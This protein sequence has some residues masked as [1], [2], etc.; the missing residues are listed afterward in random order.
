LDSGEPKGPSK[1]ARLDTLRGAPT[2][3]PEPAVGD[4]L[5]GRYRLQS[6]IGRGG[7]GRVFVAENLSIGIQVAIKVVHSGLLADNEFRQRFQREAQIIASIDHPNV[8]RFFDLVLGDPAFLVMEYVRGPTLSQIL[9]REGTMQIARAVDLAVRLCWGLHSVHA[10]GVVHRDLKPS[11]IIVAADVERGEM[12]KVI[13][14]GLA[15]IAGATT[16]GAQLTRTGQI[17]GTP[18]YMSP[19]QITGGTVDARAD[20]YSLACVLFEMLTNRTPFERSE[21]VQVLYR[22]IHE[23]PPSLSKWRPDAPPALVAVLSRGLAKAPSDRFGSMQEMAQALT[24]AVEKRASRTAPLR[25]RLLRGTA[26]VLAGAATGGL[27][28]AAVLLR[29]PT[30]DATAAG[31]TLVLSSTPSDAQILVDGKAWPETTPTAVRGLGSGAHA[32]RMTIKGR[33]L[34]RTVNLETGQRIALDWALPPPIRTVELQTVPA[35]ATVFVDGRIATGTTPLS[36]TVSDDDMHALRFEKEGYESL[37]ALI[38]PDD[39]QAQKHYEL[40]VEQHEKATLI[41]DSIL[42][43]EVWIDGQDTG[44]SSPSMAMRVSTGAH[45][46][47]LRDGTGRVLGSDHISLRR[48][49]TR[50]LSMSVQAGKEQP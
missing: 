29:H 7:M 25:Q 19:E 20:V 28:S 27:L 46:I 38:E 16:D 24:R 23:P 3:E 8:A 18:L 6:M 12:P 11:N 35:G 37:P 1:I 13:D 39:N 36:I 33:S 5:A 15:K 17:I 34:E 21:D 43:G 48:G 31:A 9:K 41:V 45:L 4:V 42:P 50:R 10:A 32:I 40:T 2:V 14:F 30:V 49:E 44:L 26:L 47:E 22:Q